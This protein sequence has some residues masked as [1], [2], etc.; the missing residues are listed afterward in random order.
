MIYT[1]TPT[2]VRIDA[3]NYALEIDKNNISVILA[4]EQVACLRPASA[5]NTV[6]GDTV[7]DDAAAGELTLAEEKTPDGYKFTWTGKSACWDKKEYI[8]LA[9]ES[10]FEYFIRVTGKGSVDTV[11]YFIGDIADSGRG[12]D[13]EFDTGYMPIPTVD[14]AAQCTFSAQRPYKEFSYLTVPP[15][16]CYTFDICGME[17][18]LAFG[19]VAD[20]G[21]HNFT[22]FNYD[23]SSANFLRRFWL[24]T[25]Q[26]GHTHVDGEWKSPSVIV[27]SA[28]SRHDALKFYSDYYFATGRAE[29]KPADEKKPRF[30]Y[31]P[32]ACGWIEQEA[33]ALK[34]GVPRSGVDMAYQPLY[35]SFNEELER[36]DLHP[37]IMIIDDKWQEQYGTD[38]VNT[39]KWPD[40]RGW[41]DNNVKENNRY[42]MLWYKLWDSEGVP[43]EM[44]MFDESNNRRV[45]DPTNPKYREYLRDQLHRL[46][47]SDEGCYNAYGLKLDYAF[48]QPVGRKAESYSGKYG[49][50]LFLEYIAYIHDCVKEFKPEAIVSASPCHPLFT[51]YVDH[52]R[53]HDYYPDLRRCYEEFAFRKEIYEIAMPGVLFDTDGA[54][55]R[56]HR[57]TMRYM[58]LAPK[59]GIPD[60]YCITSLPCL[61]LTDDDWATVANVWREY[62]A[63]IDKMFE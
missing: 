53:L 59:I 60:L 27:Y 46:I 4:G 62:E 54:A 11:N 14:G 21:Q 23:T 28:P 42:T 45:V 48:C 41:I 39:E 9:K 26:S 31:G 63:K 32:M 17:P 24:W 51:K 15:M 35:D 57:D 52:A 30:W 58:T 10:H 1:K 49:V 18:K 61:E 16:F 37:Q 22:Q 19:L 5:V 7:T 29:A 13:Y 25:D 34:H 2:A 55:F 43:E 50:E 33:Y 47:S 20:P 56:T 44:T 38:I 40:L 12:S 36:R 8:V 3:G 6:S